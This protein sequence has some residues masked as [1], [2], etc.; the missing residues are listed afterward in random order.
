MM[1]KQKQKTNK[2]TNKKQTKKKHTKIPIIMKSTEE[3]LILRQEAVAPFALF[4]K[5]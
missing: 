3:T 4:A 1:R 2:Q 5:L